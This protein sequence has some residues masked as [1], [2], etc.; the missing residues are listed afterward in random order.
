MALEWSKVKSEHVA[1]ACALIANGRVKSEARE[2]GLFVMFQGQRLSAK[3]VVRLAYCLAHHL[4]LEADVKF[5][6][7]EGTLKRL[8]DLG[9][10]VE[11]V[12]STGNEADRGRG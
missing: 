7:G 4:S 10:K 5:A 2:K 12:P 3:Q 11:R 1:G 6:S 8:Q 9:A